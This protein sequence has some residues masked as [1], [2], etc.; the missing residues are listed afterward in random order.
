MP[1]PPIVP[2][3]DAFRAGAGRDVPG[4][5]GRLRLSETAFSS[6]GAIDASASGA[7]VAALAPRPVTVVRP[8]DLLV[9]TFSFVN[10]QFGAAGPGSEHG[11]TPRHQQAGVPGGRVPVAARHRAGLLRGCRRHPGQAA[12]ASAGRHE[13][14]PRSAGARLRREQ[15]RAGCAA[16]DPRAHLRP[17]TPRVPGHVRADSVHARGPPG[18]DVDPPVERRPQRL[19]RPDRGRA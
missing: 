13:P 15:Q 6:T 4:S 7:I 14:G 1:D 17:L 9:I 12:A 11:E 8:A 16:A 2:V 18:R 5:G 10:M 3:A 19:A